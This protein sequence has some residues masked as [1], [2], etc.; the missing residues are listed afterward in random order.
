M[1]H[2]GGED[3]T[4]PDDK[5]WIQV[6]KRLEEELREM[7][8]QKTRVDEWCGVNITVIRTHMQ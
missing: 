4:K 1:L 5:H 8:Y 3:K 6:Y 7:N 2:A